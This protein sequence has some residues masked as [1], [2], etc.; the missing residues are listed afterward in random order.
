MENDM[1]THIARAVALLAALGAG[2]LL[3]AGASPAGAQ[4]LPPRPTAQP[5]ATPTATSEATT[6]PAPSEA[7]APGRITG[8]VINRATGA[9]A[10]GVAVRVGDA[11]VATD[12]NG[13]YDHN[14][15]SSGSYMVELVLA[16]APGDPVPTAVTIEL[17]AGA[18]VVQHLTFGRVSTAAPDPTLTP[19]QLPAT[20]AEQ[21]TLLTALLGAL[22]LL[23]AGV[24]LRRIRQ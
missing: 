2:A 3:A 4:T 22:A 15:L 18:T 21:G 12:A 8:T 17:A 20:G 7:A 10:T 23:A 24:G 5:T 13:N 9:P 14:G 6:A 11:T 19:S 16:I 1:N